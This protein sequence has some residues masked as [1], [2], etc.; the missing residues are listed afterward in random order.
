MNWIDVAQKKY[1]WWV[2][3]NVVLSLRFLKM[4][5]ISWQTE[6]QLASEEGLCSVQLVTVITSHTL[7]NRVLLDKLI[8]AQLLKKFLILLGS[9]PLNN[10]CTTLTLVTILSLM[11][12]VHTVPFLTHPFICYPPIYTLVFQDTSSIQVFRQNFSIHVW[13]LACMQHALPVPSS[14]T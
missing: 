7:H 9:W 12:P 5:G 2:L 14:L 4:R 8:F 1:R 13:S 6:N 3:V 11:I 10:V